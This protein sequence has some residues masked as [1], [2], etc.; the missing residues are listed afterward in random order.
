MSE[1][2]ADDIDLDLG[3]EEVH[4]GGVPERVRSDPAAGSRV[5]ELGGVAPDDLVD[6]VAGERLPASGEHG[7]SR[8]RG[9]LLGLEQ[10]LDGSGGLLPERA[11]SPFVAVAMQAHA[12]VL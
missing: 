2:A 6:P 4:G 10:L 12:R 9:A 5:V 7:C 8:R 1:P 3:F 11:G